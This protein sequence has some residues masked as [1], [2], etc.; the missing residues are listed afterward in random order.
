MT[1]KNH[2]EAINT[3]VLKKIIPIMAKNMPN[4][5]PL[6]R[7]KCLVLRSATMV[8]LDLPAQFRAMDRK[9]SVLACSLSMWF[10]TNVWSFVAQLCTVVLHIVF[11]S[12]KAY[13]R[14]VCSIF[15]V[16]S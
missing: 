10:H 9:W 6:L 3:N 4:L 2:E 14:T 12:A 15:R 8:V 16:S 13:P 11:M 1:T 5:K 7:P